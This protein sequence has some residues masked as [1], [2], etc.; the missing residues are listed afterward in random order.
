MKYVLTGVSSFVL[1]TVLINSGVTP[2][3]WQFWVVFALILLL[4]VAQYL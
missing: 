2:A 4:I 1:T 3:T